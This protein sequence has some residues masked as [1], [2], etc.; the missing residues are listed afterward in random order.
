MNNNLKF[1]KDTIYCKY[2][3]DFKKKDYCERCKI[4]CKSSKVIPEDYQY[5]EEKYKAEI[6]PTILEKDPYED[7]IDTF[8]L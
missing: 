8:G 6:L 7:E 5:D 3:Y 1:E 4:L 2:F